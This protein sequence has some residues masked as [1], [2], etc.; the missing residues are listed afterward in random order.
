M[1]RLDYCHPQIVHALEKAGWTVAD[2]PL[3]IDIPEREIHIDIE[4]WRNANGSRQHIMLAEVKCFPNRQSTTTE[5]YRSIGQYIVYR[6][7]LST[8]LM[9]IPLYLAIPDAVYDTV[10]DSTVRRA[11]SDNKMKLLIVN[12]ETEAIIQWIE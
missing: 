11:V 5:L 12:L 3:T 6:A 7:V 9:D 10:F 1:S 4:A 2:M 8:T